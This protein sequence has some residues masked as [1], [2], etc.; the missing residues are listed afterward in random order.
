MHY[1]IASFSE[2]TLAAWRES[3]GDLPGV[4]FRTGAGSAVSFDCDA[5]LMNF[6]LAHDR[7][8]GTPEIGRAQV[9]VNTRND[10]SPRYIV[11]TPP[12]AG[13]GPEVTDPAELEERLHHTFS[14][15]FDAISGAV[16]RDPGVIE[17][18]LVHVEGMGLEEIGRE[19][20]IR[21]LRRALRKT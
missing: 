10:S 13:G 1:V 14:A 3:L 20:S 19:P 2:P 12:F 5:Q 7:Y 17:R 11:A 18:V 16:E 15:C 6:Y 9:L 8:G 4:T 21:A